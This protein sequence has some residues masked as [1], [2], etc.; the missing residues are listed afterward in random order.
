MTNRLPVTLC[1]AKNRQGT[2]CRRP[3]GWGTDH[4]KFGHC[5]LHAGS[6][7]TG[8]KFALK[9]KILWEDKLLEQIG[10]S[11]K[12]LI[13]LRDDA[14]IPARDRIAAARDLLDRAGA[15]LE[16]R[17]GQVN[18]VIPVIRWPGS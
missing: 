15:T 1:G 7:E 14:D 13:N 12:L 4:Q 2:P 18:I 17:A 9:Q 11:L 6:T 5:K 16:D 8:A 3:A 10:P